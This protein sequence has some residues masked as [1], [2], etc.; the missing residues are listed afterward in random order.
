M[1]YLNL[2]FLLAFAVTV[3]NY[4]I[5]GT[6]GF[7]PQR[8][9]GTGF[10]PLDPANLRGYVFFGRPRVRMATPAPTSAALANGTVVFSAVATLA[11]DAP[12]S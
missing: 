10:R 3:S 7:R 8:E 11:R 9:G 4:N 6:L 12:R 2:R 5:V 1:R